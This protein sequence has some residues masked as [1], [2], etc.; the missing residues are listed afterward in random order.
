MDPLTQALVSAGPGEPYTIGFGH[1]G[2]VQPGD[3]CTQE[4]ADEWLAG[5]V[6]WSAGAVN[7]LV[8]VD[9]E[10]HQFDPL[11][12]LCFL[13]SDRGLSVARPC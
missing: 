2:G 7:H 1:T 5:D 9:L 3:T 13:I 6:A 8:T 10:Q 4:Q 12:S 11:V